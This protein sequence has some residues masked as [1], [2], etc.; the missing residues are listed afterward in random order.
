MHMDVLSLTRSG[1]RRMILRQSTGKIGNS[2][3]AG[4]AT[5]SEP[6]EEK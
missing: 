3:S 4:F 5:P 6:Q 1:G 2:R